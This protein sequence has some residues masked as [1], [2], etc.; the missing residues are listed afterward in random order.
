MLNQRR[1]VADPSR[2]DCLI[3]ALSSVATVFAGRPVFAKEASG[4]FDQWVAAFAG[5]AL[6][7]G[8]TPQTYTRVMSGLKPDT[9]GL[10]AIRSQ[11]EFN[12]QLWQYLNRRVSDWRVIAGK[13]KAQEYAPLFARIKRDYG[14]EPSIMLGVWG[15]E[16]TFGDPLVQKNHMRP[17]IP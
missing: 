4:S 16:S 12:E 9:T 1:V 6:A 13:A 15:V 5:K 17:V 2:R 14:V 7:Q 11:P 10:E 3:V 8:I